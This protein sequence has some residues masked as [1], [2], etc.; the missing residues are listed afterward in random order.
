MNLSPAVLFLGGFWTG[1]IW[2]W[3]L[4]LHRRHMIEQREKDERTLWYLDLATSR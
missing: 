3:S 2:F 1:M 4:F